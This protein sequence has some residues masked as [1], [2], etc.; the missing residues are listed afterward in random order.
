MV[1][2]A[3]GAIGRTIVLQFARDGVTNIAG[4]DL[5][6]SA[7]E[8]VGSEVATLFPE[9]EFLPLTGDLSS[10]VQVESMF[11]QTIAKFQRLDYVVNNAGIGGPF[12]PTS[13]GDLAA[14]ERVMSVNL[15]G[16]WLCERAALKQMLTQEPLAPQP[17]S[18]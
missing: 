3:G 13:E 10:E 4:I 18:P 2:G 16:L 9:V 7:L 1:T 11:Q 15:K 8:S 5:S 6:P 14:F 17:L 12:T